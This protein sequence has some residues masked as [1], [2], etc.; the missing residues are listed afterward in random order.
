MRLAVSVVILSLFSSAVIAETTTIAAPPP[1]LGNYDPT[2]SAKEAV[3]ANWELAASGIR[4]G[5]VVGRQVVDLADGDA[6]FPQLAHQAKFALKTMLQRYHAAAWIYASDAALAPVDQDALRAVVEAA[7]AECGDGDC[8]AERAAL[9]ASFERASADLE[10]A[11]ASARVGV[12]ARRDAVDAVLMAE[13]LTI[14]ADYLESDAWTQGLAGEGY[15]RD[16]DV[17]SARLVG[18][19]ALWRN[20]EPYVGLIAP[21]IDDAINDASE[22]VLRTVVRRVRRARVI[23]ASGEELAALRPLTDALAAEFR[24]AAALFAA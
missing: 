21:E 8:A 24:R 20:V 13:Q 4:A 3:M 19:V 16:G 23:E 15:G 2:L 18:A 17:V 22:Q 9:R 14:V 10:S 11:A 6:A 5:A 1:D 12:A 7:A